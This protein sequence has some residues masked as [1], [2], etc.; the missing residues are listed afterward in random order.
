MAQPLLSVFDTE[1]VGYYFSHGMTTIRRDVLEEGLCAYASVLAD[2]A[3]LERFTRTDRTIP[4]V[5]TAA[6][7]RWR[8]FSFLSNRVE[9]DIV[10][11][12]F[13]LL[14]IVEEAAPIRNLWL[15]LE[16]L[17]IG[18]I[19][20]HMPTAISP[21]AASSSATGVPMVTWLGAVASLDGEEHTLLKGRTTYTPPSDPS[22]PHLVF[23]SAD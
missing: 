6:W 1:R 8:R 21:Q 9:R 14:Y 19:A 15:R 13:A 16:Q 10:L 11:A 2:L 20:Q 12:Y 5:F 17:L 3:I 18:F 7:E 23:P 4:T 22:A